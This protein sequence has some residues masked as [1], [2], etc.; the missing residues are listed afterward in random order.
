M[1]PYHFPRGTPFWG[2]V[3][4]KSE[5]CWEWRGRILQ[6]GYGQFDVKRRPTAAHRYAYELTYG[7]IPDG[8]IVCHRC[9]NPRC[10]RPDHLFL[11][12]HADNARDKSAKGRCHKQWLTNAQLQDICV[13]Y[14]SGH[15]DISDLACKHSV[16]PGTIKRIVNGRTRRTAHRQHV[17]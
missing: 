11:G 9:D 15:I 1:G 4:R 12:S 8:L 5:G 17:K 14:D 16:S 6:N 10:V 7:A 2:R 3:E 13:E